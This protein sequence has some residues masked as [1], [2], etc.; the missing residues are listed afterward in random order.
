MPQPTALPRIELADVH[1]HSGCGDIL[2]FRGKGIIATAIQ[3]AGRSTYS[4]AA[5]LTYIKSIPCCMEMR[6]FRGG[7]LVTL[8]SQVER[9]PG[10]IDLY[11]VREE[12]LFRYDRRGACRAM[13]LKCGREYSY[14]GI[15]SAAANHAFGLRLLAKPNTDDRDQ[16]HDALPEF[17]SQAVSNA[18]RLGGGV[19]PVQMA[20]DKITEPADLAQSLL[21]EPKGTLWP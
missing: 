20:S 11:T 4:H 16:G 6:E 3:K 1:R 21:W 10:Q 18:A 7:R 12:Y 9:F 15:L 8:D 2:L 14:A 17:C 19:D 5:M 13:L